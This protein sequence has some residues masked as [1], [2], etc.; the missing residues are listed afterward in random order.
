MCMYI[1]NNNASLYSA[2]HEQLVS[3]SAQAKNSENSLETYL[4][5]FSEKAKINFDSL[6][7]GLPQE[8][9]EI[10]AQ[11]LNSIG[12]AAAFS[13]MNGFESQEER[14]VVSQYFGNFKGILSDDAIKKM[15]LSKLD[16]PNTQEKGFLEA[17]AQALD[18]P[19][20]SINITV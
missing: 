1:Q 5:N 16:N 10:L 2:P 13:S 4:R 7:S 20:K 17:F 8:R 12:K 19:L 15:I 18:S 6:I 11:E 14:L 3:P 9:K